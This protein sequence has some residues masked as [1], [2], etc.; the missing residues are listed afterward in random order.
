ME[1]EPNLV[2]LCRRVASG[3]SAEK[4]NWTSLDGKRRKTLVDASSANLV[5]NV[6]GKLSEAN[7]QSWA[8]LANKDPIRA[9]NILWKLT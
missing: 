7:R 8:A 2:K 3:H 4:H 6:W 9:I 5:V 1:T